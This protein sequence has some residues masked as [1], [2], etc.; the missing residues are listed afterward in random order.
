M[1]SNNTIFQDT[2]KRFIHLR[3]GVLSQLI[4]GLILITFR[5]YLTGSSPPTFA[6][7][8][9]PA[10]D[11]DDLVTRT[12]T[13][14][15]LPVMN[16]WLLLCPYNLSFD[17]SMGT[18]P[19]VESILDP[20]NIYS[21]AFYAMLAVVALWIIISQERQ[22]RTACTSHENGYM[23]QTKHSNGKCSDGELNGNSVG[24][25]LHSR[26]QHINGRHHSKGAV[27]RNHKVTNGW[28]K[29]KTQ[30]NHHHSAINNRTQNGNS[31]SNLVDKSIQS[32]V[33]EWRRT[34]DILIMSLALLV[35]PFLPASNLFFYVGFVIA[36]RILYIPSMGYCLSLAFGVELLWERFSRHRVRQWTLSVLVLLLISAFSLRTVLRNQDWFSEEMLYR[37]GIHV[38]PPKAWGNLANILKMEGKVNEAETAYRNALKH[39]VNMADVHYNLGILLQESK[40]F[41]EAIESYQKAIHFRPRLSMA[42]LNL[43]IVLTE[44]GRLKEAEYIYLHAATLT[45]DGLKDPRNQMK[46]I[47]SSMFNLGRLMQNQGRFEVYNATVTV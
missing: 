23:Q 45:D 8:D 13:F 14:L 17:W 24:N 26:Y 10:A 47:I 34:V 4:A 31:I 1:E 6:P 22:D 18:I 27:L 33:T 9:N 11:S 15:L 29:S 37:S 43:G 3:Q 44:V 38:N 36:E 39:R 7:A 16:F 2:S 12:L 20:R 35:F 19:L 40:R 41:H 46:G 32:E 42:H 28:S 21:L 5:L 30:A 25:G